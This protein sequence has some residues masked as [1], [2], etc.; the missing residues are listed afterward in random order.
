MIRVC[1]FKG[2]CGDNSQAT[3]KLVPGGIV[4]LNGNQ[5]LSGCMTGNNEACA[6]EIRLVN[7]ANIAYS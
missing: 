6:Y 4:S 1:E 2:T 7:T 3:G 5:D